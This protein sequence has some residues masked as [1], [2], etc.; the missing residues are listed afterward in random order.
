MSE[1]ERGL[2]PGLEEQV[3]LLHQESVVR[4]SVALGELRRQVCFK[5]SQ[6][7]VVHSEDR[8]SVHSE[9]V[10]SG[11]CA[12]SIGRQVVEHPEHIV[13]RLLLEALGVWALA[14]SRASLAHF[15]LEPDHESKINYRWPNR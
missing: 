7:R 2:L 8:A 9:Q 13:Q 14:L 15:L 4:V 6:L 10:V 5:V 1:P 11:H 12:A 3:Q